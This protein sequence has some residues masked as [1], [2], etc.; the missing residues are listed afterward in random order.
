MKEYALSMGAISNGK[1][2]V[3]VMRAW[4]GAQLS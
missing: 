4:D 3:P 1:K 2:R